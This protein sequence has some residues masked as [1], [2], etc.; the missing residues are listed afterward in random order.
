LTGKYVH[1]NLRVWRREFC[2]HIRWRKKW[3]LRV[4]VIFFFALTP[5][6]RSLATRQENSAGCAVPSLDA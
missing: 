6:R 3:K 4:A 1:E 2:R 5:L